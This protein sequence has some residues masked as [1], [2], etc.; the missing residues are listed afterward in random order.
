[1]RKRTVNNDLTE[2]IRPS[3]ELNKNEIEEISQAYRDGCKG[4]IL[5]GLRGE[6]RVIVM[7]LPTQDSKTTNTAL[8]QDI[9]KLRE[10]GCNRC[11]RVANGLK[12]EV[13]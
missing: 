1:M 5:I 7:F 4:E 2:I 11:L 10:M 12:M 3:G 13:L 8:K 9:A 6:E